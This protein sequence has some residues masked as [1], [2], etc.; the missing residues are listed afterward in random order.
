LCTGATPEPDLGSDEVLA[1]MKLL[2]SRIE[3][4][5]I[6]RKLGESGR[7]PASLRTLYRRDVNLTVA[8]LHEDQRR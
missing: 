8:L 7:V 5:R 1:L 3:A 6:L 2:P 4:E